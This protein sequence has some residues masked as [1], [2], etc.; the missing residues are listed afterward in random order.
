[1]HLDAG[2]ALPKFVV[3]WWGSFPSCKAVVAHASIWI[4]NEIMGK[5]LN[6]EIMTCSP[7]L[8]V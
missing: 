6:G 2:L 7:I 8:L 4:L 3:C 5:M 1:M